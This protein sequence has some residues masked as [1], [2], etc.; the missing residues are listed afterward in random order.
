M[1]IPLVRYLNVVVLTRFPMYI[2]RCLVMSFTTLS[3]CNSIQPDTMWSVVSSYLLHI[4]HSA[5]FYN[6]SIDLVAKL[7]SCA[8][9]IRPFVWALS[10]VL[11]SHWL[12]LFWSTSAA[13]ALFKNLLWSTFS[14]HCFHCLSFALCFVFSFIL[15]AYMVVSSFPHFFRFG[16]SISCLNFSPSFWWNTTSSFFSRCHTH[17]SR[18]SPQYFKYVSNPTVVVL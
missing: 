10:P 12:V 9:I 2:C 5:I 7:W 17:W 15:F 8:A 1:F 13:L 18:V 6:S 3:F 16:T 4:L 14:S 11:L